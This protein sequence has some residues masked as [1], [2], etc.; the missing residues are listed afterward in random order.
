MKKAQE[1]FECLDKRANYIYKQANGMVCASEYAPE[2]MPVYS[3]T[4]ATV[5]PLSD[6]QEQLWSPLKTIEKKDWVLR[7]GEVWCLGKVDVEEFAGLPWDKCLIKKK[8]SAVRYHD[9]IGCLGFFWN[10]ETQMDAVMGVLARAVR[11]HEGLPVYYEGVVGY[12]HF[13][14]IRRYQIKFY[15]D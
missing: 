8:Q 5:I 15:E 9:A 1:L 10:G 14:P 7:F 13:K 4:P 11:N 2:K 12:E 6:I 3:I